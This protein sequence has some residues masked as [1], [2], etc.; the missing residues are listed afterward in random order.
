MTMVDGHGR[1][2]AE[3]HQRLDEDVAPS[4]PRHAASPRRR[5][6]PL[7]AIDETVRHNKS[8]PSAPVSWRHPMEDTPWRGPCQVPFTYHP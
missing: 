5:A 6:M 7:R 8:V 2:A 1:D 3:R 4:R